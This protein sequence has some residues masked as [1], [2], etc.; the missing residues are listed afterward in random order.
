MR[1]IYSKI[2]AGTLAALTLA[3]CSSKVVMP[4]IT[5][6]PPG[7]DWRNAPVFAVSMSEFDFTPAH[8]VFHAGQPLR[9]I[10][11]NNGTGEHDFSAPSFFAALNY[12]SGTPLPTAGKIAL[13]AGE[14]V[15]LDVVPASAGEYPL[16]CTI[17]LHSMFGMTGLI[18]VTKPAPSTLLP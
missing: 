11:V 18:T 2:A 8:P 17:F 13:N 5:L 6:A 7:I 9:L 10:I 14:K 1:K 15:E 3:A 16:E 4:P 12:R